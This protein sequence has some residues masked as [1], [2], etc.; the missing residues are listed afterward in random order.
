MGIDIQLQ[1]HL[2]ELAMRWIDP[3]ASRGTQI[4]VTKVLLMFEW[5]SFK[6]GLPDEV[7]VLG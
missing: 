7:M 1:L 5:G 3:K 4:N 2:V 6:Y